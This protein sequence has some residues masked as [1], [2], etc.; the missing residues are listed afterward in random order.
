M[1]FI[2]KLFSYGQLQVK[3]IVKDDVIASEEIDGVVKILHL[4]RCC[5]IYIITTYSS[6]P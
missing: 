6:T 4:R 2:T 1:S 3:N 5:K